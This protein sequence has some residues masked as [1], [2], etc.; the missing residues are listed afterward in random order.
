MTNLLFSDLK[1]IPWQH[2]YFSQ[3]NYRAFTIEITIANP[4][5]VRFWGQNALKCCILDI[6]RQNTIKLCQTL[7]ESLTLTDKLIKKMSKYTNP[8]AEVLAKNLLDNWQGKHS[9]SKGELLETHISWLILFDDYVYK[10][11]KSVNFGFVDF[12]TLEKRKFYCEEEIRLNKRTAADIYLEVIAVSGTLN[13]PLPE[14]KSAP[15]EYLVKMKRFTSGSLL[16]DWVNQ[17]KVTKKLIEGLAETISQ[18]HK[19]IETSQD[20]A[21]DFGSPEQVMK[22]IRD[23][24][25]HLRAANL[26]TE[27]NNLL[28]ELC[29]WSE[30]AFK[31]L[32]PQLTERKNKGFIRE[33]HGDMH[34][35]NIFISKGRCILFDCIEFNPD[36]RWIDMAS[37]LAFTVMDLDSHKN[38][39]LSHQLLNQYLEFTGDYDSLMV[40]RFYMIYRA[41]VRAKVCALRGNQAH[42]DRPE[43]MDECYGYMQLAQKYSN[44]H[45]SSLSIMCGLSGTG[46]T[47]VARGL[48]SKTG[49]IQLRSDVER[50]RIFHLNPGEDSKVAG[51]DIYTEDANKQTFDQLKVLARKV[52]NAGFSAIIDATFLQRDLRDAFR[53]IATESKVPFFIIHTVSS[54]ADAKERLIKRKGDASEAGYQQYQEQK[55][56]FDEF[57]DEELLL[58]ITVNTSG[59]QMQQGLHEAALCIKQPESQA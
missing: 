50:K 59:D 17:K 43:I 44:P 37:D 36:L 5:Y 22:P 8:D 52:L 57:T 2:F 33:C 20:E 16:L 1:L 58:V 7:I 18:F 56:I 12:S 30:K 41:M 34:L 55:G 11:K 15:F 49:A 9:E 47:T 13:S 25:Q 45:A 54:T 24:F 28:E 23:N 21:P 6:S 51:H 31:E 3:S 4:Y 46:K 27:K 29:I 39:P 35:G 48:V 10:L 19:Q 53:S 26:A 32:T 38:Q 42:V 40:M 14:N